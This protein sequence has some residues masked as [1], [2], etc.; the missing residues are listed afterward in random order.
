MN[1][2]PSAEVHRDQAWQTVIEVFEQILAEDPDYPDPEGLLQSAHAA[3]EMAR[4]EQDTIRR[5]REAAEWA[6]V[7]ED[8]RGRDVKRLRDLANRLELSLNTAA[9]IE[10][11]VMGETKEAILDRQEQ[12]IAEQYRK[13]LEE[14]WTDERATQYRSKPAQHLSE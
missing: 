5:Y 11:A 14:A 8:L 13:A 1:S 3:Q 10:R 9:R 2:M 6:W 12:V 4:K 7:D